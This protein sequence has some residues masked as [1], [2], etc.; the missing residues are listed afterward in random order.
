MVELCIDD[1][2]TMTTQDPNATEGPK[3]FSVQDAAEG[4]P[5]VAED[6]VAEDTTLS[7]KKFDIFVPP[8][9]SPKNNA[10][11]ATHHPAQS[12]F[13]RRKTR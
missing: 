6:A 13:D 1:M 7:K 12:C 9:A 3:H 10:P 2:S 11:P 8:S 4:E 5:N